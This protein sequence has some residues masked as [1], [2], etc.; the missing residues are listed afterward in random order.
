MNRVLLL[1]VCMLMCANLAVGK[2]FEFKS[3][4]T[5]YS[6]DKQQVLVDVSVSYQLH[7]NLLNDEKVD[8]LLSTKIKSSIRSICNDISG[9]ESFLLVE[10]KDQIL[11]SLQTGLKRAFVD[12]SITIQNTAVDNITLPSYVMQAIEAKQRYQKVVTEQMAEVEK[13]KKQMQKE[14]Q[15]QKKY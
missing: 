7:E 2:S 15:D 3:S 4:V 6:Q 12:G 9:A 10:T 5:A 11:T 8:E 14:R 13:M 1:M